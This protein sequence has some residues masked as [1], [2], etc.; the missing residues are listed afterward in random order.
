MSIAIS[1]FIVFPPL[2]DFIIF[3]CSA[4]YAISF[5]ALSP[6]T[7][8]AERFQQILIWLNKDIT[9]KI[10]DCKVGFG[11]IVQSRQELV[12]KPVYFVDF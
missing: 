12:E 6:F 2:D 1:F 11:F 10:P 7:L 4:G 3:Y 8:F 9:I 5:S